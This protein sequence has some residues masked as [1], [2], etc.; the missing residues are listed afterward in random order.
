MKELNQN[1]FLGIIIVI[2]I[3]LCY[4]AQQLSGSSLQ[5]I[6]TKVINATLLCVFSLAFIKF[7]RGTKN[8]II[9]EIFKENSVAAALYVGMFVIAFAIAITVNS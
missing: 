8:D 2:A 1:H 5:I 6:T 9:E 4:F 3:G 7:T